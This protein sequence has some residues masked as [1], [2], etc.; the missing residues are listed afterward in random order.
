MSGLFIAFRSL[1]GFTVHLT[2]GTDG[3][4]CFGIGAD[5]PT[6]AHIKIVKQNIERY[7]LKLER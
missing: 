6:V 5:D 3:W 4:V 7:M 1:S 2:Y